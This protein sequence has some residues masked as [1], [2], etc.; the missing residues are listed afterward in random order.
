[1]EPSFAEVMLDK[2]VRVGL[3]ELVMS[4]MHWVE[5]RSSDAAL[6]GR[7]KLEL[8]K[9]KI[10]PL[11]EYMHKNGYVD[12][13]QYLKLQHYLNT[14]FDLVEGIVSA[15]A[16]ISKN[17]ELIQLAKEVQAGCSAICR[18]RERK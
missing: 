3:P 10:G 7:E 17:P 2:N 11:L 14:S 12:G 13:E 9:S 18:K 16:T 4:T 6:Q 8:F 1:M 15:Y 5:L